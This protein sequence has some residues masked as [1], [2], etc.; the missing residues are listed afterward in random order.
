MRRLSN[1][2][3]NQKLDYKSYEQPST[4]GYLANGII[5]LFPEFP[6]SMTLGGK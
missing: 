6:T 2:K 1:L 3:I 5:F 4:A